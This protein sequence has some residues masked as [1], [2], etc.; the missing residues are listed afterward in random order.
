MQELIKIEQRELGQLYGNLSKFYAAMERFEDCYNGDAPEEA[1]AHFS[2]AFALAPEKF[3]STTC[4]EDGQPVQ[5]LHDDLEAFGYVLAG[6][7]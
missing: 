5:H 4:G 6:G 2:E 3:K 7:Q 1:G